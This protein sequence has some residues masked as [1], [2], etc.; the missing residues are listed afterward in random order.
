MIP[1]VAVALSII[2]CIE[3][4][5]G[6]LSNNLIN[7]KRLAQVRTGSTNRGVNL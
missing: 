7:Y 6:P 4:T 5:M 1:I 3:Y 2:K